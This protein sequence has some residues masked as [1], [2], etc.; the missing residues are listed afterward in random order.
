MLEKQYIPVYLYRAITYDHLSLYR[1]NPEKIPNLKGKAFAEYKKEHDLIPYPYENNVKYL[2]FFDSREVAKQYAKSLEADVNRKTCIAMF[3]FDRAALEKF[4]TIG[5]FE[6]SD[7]SY[8]LVGEYIMP[9][10]EYDPAKHFAGVMEV[11]D[12]K[13]NV[14]AVLGEEECEFYATNLAAAD[15][16]EY[17]SDERVKPL[18][19]EGYAER[20]IHLYSS[21]DD[22]EDAIADGSHD[23]VIPFFVEE[24]VLKPFKIPFSDG[25]DEYLLP[26]SLMT[27]E[28]Y[29]E[30]GYVPLK[31]K[32]ERWSDPDDYS[33]WGMFGF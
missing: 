3:K 28:N 27:E 25:S 2:H 5:K 23:V 22:A 7:G 16:N 32:E 20:A 29:V 30:E 1:N 21:R 9:L 11:S 15:G 13:P 17:L 4:K 12:K 6:N 33:A 8:S 26:L 10:S 24:S 19:A 31:S 14:F 18:L